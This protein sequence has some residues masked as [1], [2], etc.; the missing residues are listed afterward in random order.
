MQ[1]IQWRT[2][3]RVSGVPEKATAVSNN[4]SGFIAVC[5]RSGWFLLLK[6]HNRSTGAGKHPATSD[7]GVK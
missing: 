4:A 3:F 2:I 6:N 1:P 5:L 7:T